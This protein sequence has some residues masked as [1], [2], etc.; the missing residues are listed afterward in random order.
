M[1]MK[2]IAA[3]L[4]CTI[5][6]ILFFKVAEQLVIKKNHNTASLLPIWVVQKKH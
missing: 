4:G 6:L 3:R 2:L 5:F 1:K